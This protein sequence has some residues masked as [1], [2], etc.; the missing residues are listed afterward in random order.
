MTNAAKAHPY[1]DSDWRSLRMLALYRWAIA[2]GAIG[3]IVS[4][5]AA[6]VIPGVEP[7]TF[8]IAG[9][10]YL[11]VA[12]GSSVTALVHIPSVRI[13]VLANVICDLVLLNC[14]LYA[15]HGISSGLGLLL[16]VPVAGAAS[17]TSTR[18]ASLLASLATLG[19]LGGEIMRDLLGQIPQ[20]DYMRSGFYGV[21]LF[22][23]CLATNALAQ[24]ARKSEARATRSQLNL[25]NMAQLNAHILERIDM[26]V[27]VIDTAGRIRTANVAA[28]Q[29]FNLLSNPVGARLDDH[30]AELEQLL[31]GWLAQPP[32]HEVTQAATLQG[33]KLLLR[34]LALPASEPPAVMLMAEDVAHIEVRAQQMK[35]AALGRLTASIAHEIRNPL[36]AIS[37]AQQLLSQQDGWQDEDQRLLAVI[38]RQSQR[39]NQIV[40]DVLG[41]SR[42]ETLNPVALP[43]AQTLEQI[44]SEYLQDKSAAPSIVLEPMDRELKLHFDFNHLRRILYNL[45]DNSSQNAGLPTEQ[46]RIVMRANAAPTTGLEIEDNGPGIRSTDAPHVFEPFYTA[47]HGGVGLGLYIV[48]ELC[49]LNGASITLQAG[50]SQGACMRIQMGGSKPWAA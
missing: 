18:S 50:S 43:L 39:I 16:I 1:T 32:T 37:Q 47:R 44:I 17:F 19:L 46:V 28:R 23:A 41:L 29:L 33:R 35:L 27:M 24:R 6:E 4:G 9:M 12:V 10:L 11:I 3:L 14:L 48:R 22:I 30:S 45:W 13:Q 40:E 49:E 20:A 21:L 31:Q 7:W 42:R 36:S 25:A 34:C 2:L 5:R 26:A 38:S 15:S 8:Y